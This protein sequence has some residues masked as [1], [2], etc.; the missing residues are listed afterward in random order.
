MLILKLFNCQD[1][2]SSD[3]AMQF[4]DNFISSADNAKALKDLITAFSELSEKCPSL[5]V[6]ANDVECVVKCIN[7][8]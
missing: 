6:D 5:L 2:K 8:S 1:L 7:D 3:F 4:E